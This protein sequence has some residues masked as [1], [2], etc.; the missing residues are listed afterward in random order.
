MRYSNL[1]NLHASRQVEVVRSQARRNGLDVELEAG[2]KILKI[3]DSRRGL[4]HL[5]VEE[6]T[7]IDLRCGH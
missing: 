2:V 5:P 4:S 3:G 6:A 1:V 7:V